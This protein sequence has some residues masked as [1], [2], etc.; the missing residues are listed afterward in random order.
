MRTDYLLNDEEIKKIEKKLGYTFKNKLYLSIAFR[1]RS[2]T[3]ELKKG[4][5]RRANNEGLEFYGDSVL[6]YIIIQKAAKDEIEALDN[7][8]HALHSEEDY[9]NFISAL[10]SKDALARIIDELDIAKY[11]L[12]SSGDIKNEVDK[13]TSVK[14]DLFEAIVGAMW[15][16]N[17]R[18]SDAITKVID[19]LID[20]R[21]DEDFLFE[22][23]DYM[24]LKEFVD[25]NP[26]YRMAEEMK[27]NVKHYRLYNGDTLIS[28]F[29]SLKMFTKY[30]NRE[31]AAGNIIDV[32][33][34]KGL[35]DLPDVIPTE[36][37]TVDN[38]I[39]KLQELYQQ[40]K[41]NINP[42]YSDGEFDRENNVWVVECILPYEELPY[43]E[44][45]F[46][47]TKMDA[48]KKAAYEM[49][50]VVAE[51]ANRNN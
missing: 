19:K 32:L 18:N 20:I 28:G 42:I 46:G 26:S 34:E 9:T 3:D 1:R 24:K 29:P 8:L 31:E 14:E 37:I 50:M 5:I 4:I 17:D 6:N 41:L 25:R 12:V 10:T 49:Y 30:Q 21:P 13:S 48:K 15:F 35:W 45:G 40:K 38:A 11:L 33:K 47:R 27:N 16:D 22:K 36:G 23:N 7:D 51:Q 44:T 43:T 39:N 2:L